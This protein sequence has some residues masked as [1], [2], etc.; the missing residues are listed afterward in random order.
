[1]L[2]EGCIDDVVVMSCG[3]L[4]QILECAAVKAQLP[5]ND[6]VLESLRAIITK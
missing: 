2:V 3:R 1:M 5:V 6:S 4:F